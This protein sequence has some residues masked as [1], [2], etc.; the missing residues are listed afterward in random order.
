MKANKNEPVYGVLTEVGDLGLGFQELNEKDQK[1]IKE[2]SK[3][4]DSYDR[5]SA[6]EK[7]PRRKY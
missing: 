3:R 5:R 7:Q 1:I 6:D 4:V 2:D